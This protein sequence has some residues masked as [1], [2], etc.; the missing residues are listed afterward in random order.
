WDEGNSVEILKDE[1]TQNKDKFVVYVMLEDEAGNVSYIASDGHVFDLEPPVITATTVNFK[2]N[3][4]TTAAGLAINVAIADGEGESGLDADTVSY[5]YSNGFGTIDAEVN[6]AGEFTIEDK[7]IPTGEY[8]ITITAKDAVGNTGTKTIHI[9]RDSEAALTIT[10]NP[11]DVEVEYGASEVTFTVTAKSDVS[12]IASYQWQKL[13]KG[14]D[15]WENYGDEIL[16][17]ET[18]DILTIANPSVVKDNGD[19]YRVIVKNAAGS[20]VISEAAVLT[21]TPIAL[22]VKPL[23]KAYDYGTEASRVTEFPATDKTNW[24]FTGA[25]APINGD[26]VTLTGKF[27]R[28][29]GNG[30]PSQTTTYDITADGVVLANDTE[31]ANVNGNYTLAVDAAPATFTINVYVASKVATLD[32]SQNKAETWYNGIKYEE[33]VH[34]VAPDGYTISADGA[35][36]GTWSEYLTVPDGEYAGGVSYFLKETA[37]GAITSEMTTDAFNQDTVAPAGK[38]KIDDN[39]WTAVVKDVDFGTYKAADIPA[40]VTVT[41]DRSGS[42]SVWYY[43]SETALTEQDVLALPAGDWKDAGATVTI[44]STG[45]HGKTAVLYIL[46]E[47]VAGNRYALSSDGFTFDTTAPE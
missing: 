46:A 47:D 21:V 41:D 15:K 18:S 17:D 4:W 5:T 10:Q 9:M 34:I 23:D 44:P 12:E 43:I 13:E 36:N 3:T 24:T 6:G 45:K 22:T 30:D 29:A 1:N 33:G 19:S 8:D 26:D 32:G 37:S 16:T 25:N 14:S 39:T 27:V 20:V 42:G 11:A 7:N 28:E 40:T 38:I 31:A 35:V 2:E